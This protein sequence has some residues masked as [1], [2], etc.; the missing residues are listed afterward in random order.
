VEIDQK[1]LKKT[2]RENRLLKRKLEKYAFIEAEYNKLKNKLSHYSALLQDTNDA[3]IIQ[4]FDGNIIAWDRGATTMY[5]WSENEAYNKTIFDITEDNK[6]SNYFDFLQKCKQK[7]AEEVFETRRKSKDGTILDIWLTHTVL[8]D[9]NGAPYAVATTE[10]D[11]TARKEA[12]KKLRESEERYRNLVESVGEGV[13]VFDL[14]KNISFANPAAINIFQTKDNKLINHNLNEF[15]DDSNQINLNVQLNKLST[16]KEINFEIEIQRPDN[17]KRLINST[18]TNNYNKDSEFIGWLAVIRDITRLKQM[19][20]DM[21]KAD[22]LESVGLLA[23]GVSHDFNNILAII[24]GNVTI[25]KMKLTS[26]DEKNLKKLDRIE[27]AANRARDLT[28]QLMSFSKGNAPIKKSISAKNLI[29]ESVDL[30]TSGKPIK[31]EFSIEDDLWNILADEGQISQVLSNLIINAGHAMPQG[32]VVQVKAKNVFLS[33]NNIFSLKKGNYVKIQIQDQGIGISKENLK[34]I[35]DPYFTTKKTGNGLGLAT[36]FQIISKHGG[37]IT[38]E[39]DLGIGTTFFLYLPKTATTDTESSLPIPAEKTADNCLLYIDKNESNRE[40]AKIM[41]RKIG[42]KAAY[43]QDLTKS[44]DYFSNNQ[45]NKPTIKG[46]IINY[47]VLKDSN[48]LTIIH[49]LKNKYP[50]LILIATCKTPDITNINT[51]L[52]TDVFTIPL[53]FS[54]LKDKLTQIIP[55]AQ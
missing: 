2:E 17:E 24:L 23:S 19:E 14:N 12:A 16:K 45:Q 34:K 53:I 29:Y 3:V 40:I 28:K 7:E 47:N 26:L 48:N 52:F 44:K 43:L 15:F 39:S 6:K 1:T 35:F 20:A 38:V 18:I 32:G 11:I 54:E 37:K 9:D 36:A 10:R 51:D 46:I 31:A 41:L 5:G 30:A 25:L 55:I 42:Y 13:I 22:K 8:N 21:I 4:N 27:T 50:K 49:N 33:E